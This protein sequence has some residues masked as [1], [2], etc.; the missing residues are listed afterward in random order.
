[1]SVV[2]QAVPVERYEA[3]A[4]NP[5]TKAGFEFAI[6]RRGDQVFHQVSRPDTAG[7]E[8]VSLARE[9]RYVVGSGSHGRAY[10]S[11]TGNY[12]FQTPINWFSQGGRWDLAP[13][14][15][16]NQNSHFFRAVDSA[17][18]YCH[19]N[20]AEPVA[21]SVNCYRAPLPVQLAIG[22]ERCHG[23]GELHVK[24]QSQ[25]D[26]AEG[27]DDTIVNP[28]ALEPVLR[29]SICQ[30]CHLQG[31]FRVLRR[32]RELYDFRPGLPLHLFWSAFLRAS[33]ESQEREAVS[34]VEQMFASKCFR[35]SAGKLGC[36]SCHD[37]HNYPA[38][39]KKAALYREACLKCH[40]ERGCSLA[41]PQRQAQN[42][43]D[44]AA[45][46]MPRLRTTDV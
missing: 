4:G 25:A 14:V 31:E 41:A 22:C 46:H 8:A 1:M 26:A 35:A 37:P 17:C 39:E 13:N 29:E 27:P 10:L 19:G 3:A 40:Q 2:S 42:Q 30:Q 21:D 7:K 20:Q 23:P 38:P 24:R 32:G 6:Q 5:F 9:V 18:I 36:L 34:H 15:S 16:Q 45:C 43:N 33:R 44:C 12:L 11:T 28:A